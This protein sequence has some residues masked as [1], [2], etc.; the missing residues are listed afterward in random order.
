MVTVDIRPS[1]QCGG[2]YAM[3]VSFPY[4]ERLVSYIKELPD[5]RW[6]KDTKEWEISLRKFTEFIEEAKDFEIELTGNLGVFDQ[7]KI[8]LPD[9]I[10]Q[11]MK[12]LPY[13]HQKEG[14]LF[15][16]NHAQWLL[17]DEQGLG[18]TKQVIDIAVAKKK[19]YGF[20]HCLIVCG[21]NGLKW[22]WLNE[23]HTHSNEEGHILGQKTKKGKITIGSTADKLNDAKNISSLPYFIITNV[24]T[25]RNAD[26]AKV[27]KTA[28][29]SDTIQ[30]VAID[31]IHKCKNPSSQQGKGILKLQ[32]EYRI[33]M[34][35][36]P[37]MNNPLD[38]YIILRWLGY[39]K[40]AFY[41]FRNYYCVM[42]GYGGYEV[43]GYRH[44]DELEEQLHDVML[45]RLKSEVLDLPEKIRVSEYVDMTPKQAVLYKEIR[46]NLLANMD[47]ITAAA[48]PLTE[49]IRLRQTTG[50][51]GIVSSTVQ[52][53]AKLDR[54][55][56]LVEE[57]VE[58][59]KKVVVFSNWTQMT[60]VICQRLA[61]YHPAVITGAIN[62][63]E[64]QKAER[65]FQTNDSCRVLVGTI[66]AM[67]TG[68]TLTAGTV[69]IF[70]D[71]PWNMALKE[72][73]ED[74]CHRIGTTSN[75]TIYTLLCKNT[76]DER[77]NQLVE[78]KGQIAGALVDGKFTGNR[79]ELVDF[80]LN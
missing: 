52:E 62:E 42:G 22:N 76:I 31:E 7:K 25:L 79:E 60:D 4:N 30:M 3:F 8:E 65:D 18:K 35:G 57:A 10:M 73:A 43:L 26:I 15:G 47:K 55:E 33:A 40:H 54:M 68:L 69:E 36:T 59:G 20:K 80:L 61:S 38:L 45:R 74:R 50:Y 71:E 23:I 5:R 63:T 72:Q 2:E 44:M 77:V 37:V 64:R 6:N 27:L 11:S 56:E 48:N 78:N 70:V 9:W 39:E 67:G 16:L 34:T 58:N 41:A 49:M 12:T 28:C 66:G 1:I 21:V 14:V 24:E 46:M 13:E 75:I 32:P 51:T 53:S 17:A 19:M 29:D